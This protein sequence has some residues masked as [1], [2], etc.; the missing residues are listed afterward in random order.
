MKKRITKTKLLKH[1]TKLVDTADAA[2]KD[3]QRAVGYFMWSMRY[4]TYFMWS[5][6]YETLLEIRDF[7]NTHRL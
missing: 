2:R 7:I 5:M 4:E 6:R 1:L 3:G